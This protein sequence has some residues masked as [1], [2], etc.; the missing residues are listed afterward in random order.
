MPPPPPPPRPD[1]PVPTLSLRIEDL[2]HPG[3]RIFL[4]S[5]DPYHALREA[6]IFVFQWLYGTTERAPKHV[7]TI[8]LILRPMD[9]VAYTTGT[10]TAKQIH[11]S[12]NH[13]VNSAQRAPAE[14]RG[15][16]T[17]E[18]VHCFQWN[19]GGTCPGGL[20]EGVADWVRL[21]SGL[22]PPHW[23]EGGDRWDA[24]YQTTAYFLRWIEVRYGEGTV[25]ELNAR[26]KEGQYDAGMFKD[27]TG[28]GVDKLWS[29]YCDE[30][31][32]GVGAVG[33]DRFVV[34]QQQGYVPGY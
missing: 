23:R 16:L 27:L 20:I 26:M 2:S 4:Q 15:V 8:Q 1:W 28:R 17:H 10:H 30:L 24:G 18:A 11:F 21:R 3:V 31:K 6:V 7:E 14:I 34:Q 33:R 32:T 25:Q 29:K 22:I 12:C 19:A 9:G 5:V 13:I